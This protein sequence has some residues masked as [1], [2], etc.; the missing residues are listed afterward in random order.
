[1]FVPAKWTVSLDVNDAVIVVNKQRK[2]AGDKVSSRKKTMLEDSVIARTEW[3]GLIWDSNEYSCGHG[4]LF[5]LIYNMWLEDRLD[6][7][8]N[9]S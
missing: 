9:L 1:M 7:T 6:A 4:A 3:I 5:T 8:K 2:S